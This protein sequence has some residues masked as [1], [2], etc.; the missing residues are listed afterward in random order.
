MKKRI[1]HVLVAAFAP[2]F[3]DVTD[4]SALHAGHNEAAKAGG[5][6]LTVTIAATAFEGQSRV[7]RHRMVYAALRKELAAGVHA[8]AIRAWTPTEYEK[9][10]SA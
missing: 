2:T 10:S 9:A 7:Q 6:H 1:E 4:D 5:T 8:L 3:L